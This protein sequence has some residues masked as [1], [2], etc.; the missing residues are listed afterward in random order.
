MKITPTMMSAMQ[1]LWQT[2]REMEKLKVEAQRLKSMLLHESNH[3]SII[4]SSFSYIK[5]YRKGPVQY[6]SIP[7][8][9]NVDL[10]E[11]RSEE[12]ETWKLIKTEG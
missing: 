7:E 10:E 2:Q 3:S 6:K 4:T 1:K 12:V 8:L 9:F 5:S 11:Y